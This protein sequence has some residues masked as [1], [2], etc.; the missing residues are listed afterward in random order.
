MFFKGIKYHFLFLIC[1]FSVN[2]VLKC[3]TYGPKSQKS[4]KLPTAHSPVSPPASYGYLSVKKND[5]LK[6]DGF[7]PHRVASK[8]SQVDPAVFRARAVAEEADYLKGVAAYDEKKAALAQQQAFKEAE[9]ARQELDVQQAR[10]RIAMDLN[11]E[12]LS[13]DDPV[14]LYEQ[15]MARRRAARDAAIDSAI[16]DLEKQAKDAD[17]VLKFLENEK[18]ELSEDDQQ[19][20]AR[21]VQQTGEITKK[22]NELNERRKKLEAA[23]VQKHEN[24]AVG[25]MMNY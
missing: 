8:P 21:N 20:L 19:A 15:T 12:A 3:Q 13:V 23:G 17:W 4:V 9:K 5:P 18:N 25:G 14:K 7:K 22:L 11:P 6:A 16:K 10:S 24:N 1:L 2:L